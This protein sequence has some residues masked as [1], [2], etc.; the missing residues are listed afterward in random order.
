MPKVVSLVRLCKIE[1]KNFGVPAAFKRRHYTGRHSGGIQKPK[2]QLTTAGS[3]DRFR[4]QPTPSEESALETARK[5]ENHATKEN[6][7]E[8]VRKKGN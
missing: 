1:T 5:K 3:Q 2:G 6:G 8:T 4:V 7:G